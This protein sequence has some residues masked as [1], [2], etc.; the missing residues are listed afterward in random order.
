VG[1]E[2]HPPS[3]LSCHHADFLAFFNPAS[4]SSHRCHPRAFQSRILP[5]PSSTCDVRT[6]NSVKRAT[7]TSLMV[8][9]SCPH[10]PR[11]THVPPAVGVVPP[12]NSTA[13]KSRGPLPPALG[14]SRLGRIWLAIGG[15][16]IQISGQ[17]RT[18]ASPRLLLVTTFRRG[19]GD[20]SG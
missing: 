14:R 2:C 15:R 17:A 5:L 8:R 1:A 3:H 12:S 13:K 4:P 7:T 19:G 11:H 6:D 16:P 10:V 20:A 18:L 9:R